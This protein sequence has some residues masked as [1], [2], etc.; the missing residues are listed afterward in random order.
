VIWRIPDEI[1]F[2]SLMQA[3]Q[4]LEIWRCDY[5]MTRPHSR[6]GWL[7]RAIYAATFSPPLSQ[8]AALRNGSALVPWLQPYMME[9]A[10]KL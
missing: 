10:A 6:I 2:T 3:R 5:N 9:I 8:G 1:S 7:G 4:A